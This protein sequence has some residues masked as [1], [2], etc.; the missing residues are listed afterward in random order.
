MLA[1]RLGVKLKFFAISIFNGL[2]FNFFAVLTRFDSSMANQCG[3]SCRVV[4]KSYHQ[5]ICGCG[6]VWQEEFHIV[7]LTTF[8]QTCSSKK[9]S[10]LCP[11]LKRKLSH[12]SLV[13]QHTESREKNNHA[14]D[15]PHSA[16]GFVWWL[17][18]SVFL[19]L[20]TLFLI[21][22]LPSTYLST[23]RQRKD[24]PFLYCRSHD[25]QFREFLFFHQT[26]K[27]Q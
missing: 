2:S 4:T 23:Y 18:Q 21:T 7:F 3:H 20:L 11:D 13:H 26:D 1:R 14:T 25:A 8:E 9:Q 15:P 6:C 27:Q 12:P 19:S 24:A 5:S 22:S 17:S 16:C 10:L